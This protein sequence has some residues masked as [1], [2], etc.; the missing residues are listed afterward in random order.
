[1]P[2]TTG[3]RETC[4]TISSWIGTRK[5]HAPYVSSFDGFDR[6]WRNLQT[7]CRDPHVRRIGWDTSFLGTGMAAAPPS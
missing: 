3:P 4:R 5:L 2:S 1:M 6:P 7:Y